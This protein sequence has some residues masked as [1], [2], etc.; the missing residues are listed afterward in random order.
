MSTAIVV[1]GIMGSVMMILI[2]ER[3]MRKPRK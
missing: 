3:I 1:I 2:F